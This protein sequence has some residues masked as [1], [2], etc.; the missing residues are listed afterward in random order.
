MGDD[1]ALQSFS[2]Y[3][4]NNLPGTLLAAFGRGGDLLQFLRTAATL[5]VLGCRLEMDEFSLN[6]GANTISLPTYPF[7]RERYWLDAEHDFQSRPD[8]ATAVYQSSEKF[9]QSSTGSPLADSGH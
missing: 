6:V 3:A 4:G 7:E 8:T 9:V 2:Q 5:Y 1:S